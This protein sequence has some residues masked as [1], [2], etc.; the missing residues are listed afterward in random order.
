MGYIGT[1]SRGFSI[2]CLRFKPCV[3]ARTCKTLA[4]GRWLAFAGWELNALDSIEKFLFVTSN[5]LLSQ[6]YPGATCKNLPQRSYPS[7]E[8]DSA[9]ALAI[10]DLAALIFST[11]C[12]GIRVDFHPPA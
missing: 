7:S 12:S 1:Q 5:F 10:P 3:T 8:T 2:R 6:A 11:Y 4:S 9:A